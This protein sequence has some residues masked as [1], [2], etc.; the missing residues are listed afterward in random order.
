M[1][2]SDGEWRALH[3]TPNEEGWRSGHPAAAN[4]SEFQN[5]KARFLKDSPMLDL[6]LRST[7]LVAGTLSLLAALG[8]AQPAFSR[9]VPADPAKMPV[10]MGVSGLLPVGQ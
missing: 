9:T 4:R 2:S 5:L 10:A 1:F 8:L 6:I 7:A 3:T